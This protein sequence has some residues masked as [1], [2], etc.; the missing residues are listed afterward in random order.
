MVLQLLIATVFQPRPGGIERLNDRDLHSRKPHR[1][2][3][4][5]PMLAFVRSPEALLSLCYEIG[6]NQRVR[7]NKISVGPDCA[8]PL[9]DISA[10][11]GVR[12]IVYQA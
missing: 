7:R 9:T 2:G 12:S 6:F 4:P 1:T 10:R 3:N 5:P 8:R 11:R